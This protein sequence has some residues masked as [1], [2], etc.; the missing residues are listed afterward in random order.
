MTMQVSVI[1]PAHNAE[2]TIAA[3]LDGLRQQKFSA[4]EFEI[5]VVDDGSSDSTRQI[6]EARAPLDDAG[7]TSARVL[8][9]TN[10]GAAAARNLGAQNARGEIVLFIDADCVPDKNWVAAM[11]A[12]FANS[13]IVGAGGRKQT[14][15]RGSVPQFIQMEFD[16]RYD[17]VRAQK[18]IDFIDSGTAAYRWQVFLQNGGFDAALSDAEDTDFSYRLAER[19]LKMAFADGAIVYHAH[20][21]SVWEYW[22]R[23]FE[24][25]CWRT[26]VY[27]RHPRKL[28]RDSRTP[29]TQKIQGALVGLQLVFIP[30]LFLGP[31]LTW[32]YA[33]LVLALFLTATP[34]VVKYW[35]RNARVALIAPVLIVGAAYAGTA[36]MAWGFVKNRFN[37]RAAE[38]QR[39]IRNPKSEI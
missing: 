26:A 28:A 19:D 10:L 33:A 24:Y 4:G 11:V 38:A 2:K 5:I 17:R 9:Q 18:Y 31:H 32:L 23:K 7:S 15:Q 16:Y 37:R 25:A 30:F 14:Q 13:E 6:A 35:A 39:K 27:A 8:A 34:F 1:I 22:R 12:P 3:C 29:L 21:T 36:G 20:P